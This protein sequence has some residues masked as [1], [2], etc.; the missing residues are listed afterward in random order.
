MRRHSA[1]GSMGA[2]LTSNSR[3]GAAEAAPRAAAPLRI[4]PFCRSYV[5]NAMGSLRLLRALTT[6]QMAG[7]TIA[8]ANPPNTRNAALRITE[9]ELTSKLSARDPAPLRG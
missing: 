5:A 8:R 7:L 4:R 3:I 2:G 6:I 9:Q 1:S